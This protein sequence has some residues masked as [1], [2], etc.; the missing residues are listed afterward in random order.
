MI[1]VLFFGILADEAGLKELEIENVKNT[2]E[3]LNE[4]EKRFPSFS[5]YRLQLFVNQ[6]QAAEVYTLKSGDEVALIPPFPG[7]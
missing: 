5:T 4:L 6:V 1:K 2:T 3:L 7:G